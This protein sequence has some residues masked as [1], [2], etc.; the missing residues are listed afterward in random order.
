[1]A[2]RIKSEAES[3]L[4]G[5]PVL[6]REW[7]SDDFHWHVLELESQGYVA[8]RETLRISPEVNPETGAILHL[9][10]IEMRRPGPDE[11]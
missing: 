8:R 5:D 2:A 6:V 4:A 1:M 11:D 3:I 9:H 7:D 10:S